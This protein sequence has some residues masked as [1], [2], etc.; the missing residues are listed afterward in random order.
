[1][2]RQIQYEDS[3]IEVPDDATD[4]EVAQIIEGRASRAIASVDARDQEAKVKPFKPGPLEATGRYLASIGDPL[5]RPMPEGPTGLPLIDAAAGVADFAGSAIADAA[6]AIPRFASYTF[7][8]ARG[9]NAPYPSDR[10]TRTPTTPVGG[11]LQESLGAAFSPVGTAIEATGISPDTAALGMDLVGTA[12]DV[13]GLGAGARAAKIGA[14]SGIRAAAD[15]GIQ[16]PPPANAIRGVPIQFNPDADTAARAAMAT[17]DRIVQPRPWG[18]EVE[19]A[20]RLG[21]VVH[22]DDVKTQASRNLPLG[23]QA[24]PPGTRVASVAGGREVAHDMAVENTKRANAYVAREL[25]LPE[26]VTLDPKVI[27]AR[28]FEHNKPYD[29]LVRRV[30]AVPFDQELMDAISRVGEARRGNPLLEETARVRRLRAQLE[31]SAQDGQPMP[32]QQ[33]LDAMRELRRDAR[34]YMNSVDDPKKLDI[35]TTYR[36]VA[37]ELE[38]ALER[39]AVQTGDST[40]LTNLR[41]ARTQQA[42][43]HNV[44]DSMKGT[45]VD[46][47]VL[48]KLKEKGIP[49]TG[50]LDEIADTAM[51]FPDTMTS[52]A[53]IGHPTPSMT[54]MLGYGKYAAKRLFGEQLIPN[55]LSEKFQ[56]KYGEF[57]PNYRPTIAERAPLGPVIGPPRPDWIPP[58]RPGDPGFPPPAPAP[59]GPIDVDM[60]L[61]PPTVFDVGQPPPTNLASMSPELQALIGAAPETPP[62][63]AAPGTSPL[64]AAVPEPPTPGFPPASADDLAALLGATQTAPGPP[65]APWAPEWIQALAD[66]LAGPQA[67]PLDALAASLGVDTS[68]LRLP[69]PPSPI[70]ARGP[71]LGVEEGFRDLSLTPG[72]S[73]ASVQGPRMDNPPVP[74]PTLNPSEI[75]TLRSFGLLGDEAA[76]PATA[77]GNEMSPEDAFW[78]QYSRD[79]A[80]AQGDLQLAELLNLLGIGANSPSPNVSR[81][82]PPREE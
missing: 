71:Y 48:A 14:R 75:E 29:E 26:G 73:R 24:H 11:A 56:G 38:G 52:K 60:A 72:A 9:S 21:F 23:Q 54:G 51:A 77:R 31:Q 79:P 45:D 58:P 3:I 69:P 74:A 5:T 10:F 30:P 22:P 18:P 44:L 46:A 61:R 7:A 17:E 55:L 42:K 2:A 12:A 32:T 34:A 1:M 76:P 15:S 20:S 50:Y 4:D 40:L 13:V 37:E 59:T 47:V 64:G 70:G 80:A 63:G 35:G 82:L 6:G 33:V 25:G 49:L 16:I 68:P 57:D 66:E 27:E 78:V 19:Q 65:A 28:L 39:A 62:L 67:P 53:G 41:N 36:S 8:K 43:L 81:R